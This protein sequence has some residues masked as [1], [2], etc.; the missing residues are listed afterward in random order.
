MP[1]PCPCRRTSLDPAMSLA[2]PLQR[3]WPLQRPMVP[4]QRH[5][6]CP[7]TILVPVL[8]SQI[9]PLTILVLVQRHKSCPGTILVFVQRHKSCP[10]TILVLDNVTNPASA[11]LPSAATAASNYT[12]EEYCTGRL[13]RYDRGRLHRKVATV[14]SLPLYYRGILHRKVATVPSRNTAQEDCH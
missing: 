12:I 11:T 10:G 3:P 4:V 13:P 2:L 8:M 9:L 6:S 7:G 14:R 1:R 5:K